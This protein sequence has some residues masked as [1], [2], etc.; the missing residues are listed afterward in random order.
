MDRTMRKWSIILVTL[1][2]SQ[3][4]FAQSNLKEGNNSFALYTKTGDFKQLENARKLADQAYVNRRDSA[5]FKN[6]LLRGLV[7]S[8]L[9]VVDSNRS[10]KY[11]ADPIEIANNALRKLTDKQ[12]VYE[13]E[14]E[15]NHI[16]RFLSNA[17][18]IQANRAS[19]KGEYEKA[20]QHFRQMDSISGEN[21]L[22][23]HNL[24]VLSEKTGRIDQALQRYRTLLSDPNTAHS[25]YILRAVN[26]LEQRDDQDGALEWLL[27]GRT[28]FP[29][30]KQILFWL[31]HSYQRKEAY[32]YI[33]PLIDEAL[34]HEPRNIELNYLAGYA[35][36]MTG[37][38]EKAIPYF[39]RVIDIDQFH[40]E[41]NFELGL[42][43]LQLFIENPNDKKN[44]NQ[45]QEYL[46]RANQIDPSAVNTLKSLAVLYDK[47]GDV[48]Q[49]ERVNNLLNQLT[50]N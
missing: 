7:Y 42:L 16:R 19:E 41:G 8:T 17:H 29:Q 11:S 47:S 43:Y 15:I 14:P 5:G 22:V 45:A 39:K 32:S 35:Y 6:N 44:H 4:L 49:L 3:L 13:S 50:V 24:A 46:L 26:V 9:A 27:R 23:K 38:S 20:Y 12:L 37:Q 40:Y 10:Q 1:C 21:N 18:L 36:E 31:I 34:G 25:A 28:L 48:I 33:L 30:N 2:S